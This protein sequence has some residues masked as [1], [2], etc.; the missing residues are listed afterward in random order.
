MVKQEY[1]FH[2]II[3]QNKCEAI[4]DQ[5]LQILWPGVL[6]FSYAFEF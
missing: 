4:R 6:A 2:S 3:I 5:I 1:T